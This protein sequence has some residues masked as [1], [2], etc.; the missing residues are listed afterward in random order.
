MAKLAPIHWRRFDKF[1]IFVGCRLMRER[2]DHRVYQ[3]PGLIRPIVVPRD[4]QLPVFIIRN[5]LR[6]LGVAIEQYLKILDQV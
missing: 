6:L 1:L 2:G 4:T 3:R 5:N